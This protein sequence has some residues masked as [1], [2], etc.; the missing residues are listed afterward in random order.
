MSAAPSSAS[1][2]LLVDDRPEEEWPR[3]EDR[4]GVAMINAPLDLDALI[5]E[6]G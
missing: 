2:I 1:S 6:A 3:P 4:D 5:K